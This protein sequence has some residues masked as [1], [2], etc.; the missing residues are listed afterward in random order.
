MVV[1]ADGTAE[2]DEQ[3]ARV[4]LRQG[5]V[6]L[7]GKDVVDFE[8]SGAEGGFKGSEVFKGYVAERQ[9]AAGRDRHGNSLCDDRP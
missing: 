8:A 9:G 7:G 5:E 4:G 2:D 6:R 3:V 1:D